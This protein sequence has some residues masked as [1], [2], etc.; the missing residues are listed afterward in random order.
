MYDENLTR[1]TTNKGKKNNN[2]FPSV[3]LIFIPTKIA[4]HHLHARQINDIINFLCVL[5]IFLHA[6]SY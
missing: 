6:P 3:T 1:I 4:S 2:F 5:L